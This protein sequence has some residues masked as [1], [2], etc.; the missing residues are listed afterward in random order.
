MIGFERVTQSLGKMLRE[1]WRLF[2]HTYQVDKPWRNISSCSFSE[3]QSICTLKVFPAAQRL[4][5]RCHVEDCVYW[6]ERIFL[7]I[8]YSDIT[9]V[10]VAG[11]RKVS[12]NNFNPKIS[13]VSVVHWSI[14]KKF[15]FHI[16]W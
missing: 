2:F 4:W 16:E 10:G 13:I 12:Y 5:I 7:Q 8:Y 14:C 9:L 1:K 6:F 15:T 11:K 3:D